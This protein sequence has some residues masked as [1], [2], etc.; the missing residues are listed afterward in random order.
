[1]NEFRTT[2]VSDTRAF[3]Y[4]HAFAA[5]P[6]PWTSLALSHPVHRSCAAPIPLT[7]PAFARPRVDSEFDI[8]G[9]QSLDFEEFLAMQ[10]NA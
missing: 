4:A 6:N 10:P 3:A 7:V 8:D 9:N 2:I 5:G 1:M